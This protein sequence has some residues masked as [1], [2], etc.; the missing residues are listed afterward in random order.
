MTGDLIEWVRKNPRFIPVLI[1]GLSLTVFFR[2]A[3]A[4]SRKE[5]NAALFGL[6]NYP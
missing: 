5:W 3:S 2:N 4:L 1:A 6:N